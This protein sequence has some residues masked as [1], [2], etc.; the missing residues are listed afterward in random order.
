MSPDKLYT[1]CIHCLHDEDD[2][3]PDMHVDRCH[4]GCNDDE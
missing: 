4:E 1:C 2:Y 3:D